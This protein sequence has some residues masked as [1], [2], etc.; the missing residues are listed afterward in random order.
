MKEFLLLDTKLDF[1]FSKCNNL[2]LDS[3]L[4]IVLL[5]PRYEAKKEIR[6]RP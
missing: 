6:Y 4:T 3:S 1:T 5:P 2:I